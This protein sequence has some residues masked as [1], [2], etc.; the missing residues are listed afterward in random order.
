MEV[1]EYR[2]HF[3]ASVLAVLKLRVLLPSLVNY[4]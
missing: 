1:A 2:I 3:R 4:F